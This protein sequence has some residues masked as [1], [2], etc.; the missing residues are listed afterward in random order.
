MTPGTLCHIKDWQEVHG[1]MA[2]WM[3]TWNGH[4][5][6]EW[7]TAFQHK[8]VAQIPLKPIDSMG[9]KQVQLIE[10]SSISEYY[11]TP[12]VTW[13]W[14]KRKQK[15]SD[16][17]LE[18]QPKET[19]SLTLREAP[20]SIQLREQGQLEVSDSPDAWRWA[21][22]HTGL[23]CTQLAPWSPWVVLVWALP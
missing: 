4:K 23:T 15:L 19:T 3:E 1:K 13:N 21:S 17:S 8:A 20:L 6:Q 10:R 14:V 5:H 18:L 7:R 22:L 16:Y 9:K 11:F 12:C 2:Q